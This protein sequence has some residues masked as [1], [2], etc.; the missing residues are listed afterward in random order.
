MAFGPKCSLEYTRSPFERRHITFENWIKLFV[1]YGPFALVLFTAMVL[2][3]KART[4]MKDSRAGHVVA[5]TAVYVLTWVAIFVM[6]AMLLAR[7]LPERRSG[8]S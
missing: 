7:P 5:R 1:T 4:Y 3:P 6:R 8:A 2:E